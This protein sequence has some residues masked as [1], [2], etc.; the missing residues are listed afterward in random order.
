MTNFVTK[1]AGYIVGVINKAA[2]KVAD[3][4][5]EKQEIPE[6]YKGVKQVAKQAAGVAVATAG[7]AGTTVA[8]TL[9]LGGAIAATEGLSAAGASPI[10]VQGA[11]TVAATAAEFAVAPSAAAMSTL[12]PAGAALAITGVGLYFGAKVTGKVAE[13]GAIKAYNHFNHQEKTVQT[14]EKTS[15]TSL[16]V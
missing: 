11:A 15:S 2:D 3:L 4:F 5:I 8:P 1:I 7:V 10:L 6:G 14:E 16:K 9:V 12:G 13:R